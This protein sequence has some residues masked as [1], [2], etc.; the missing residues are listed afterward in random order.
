MA[1]TT[2]GGSGG[3]PPVDWR[4]LG[5]IAGLCAF[6]ILFWDW[7][8][9][10]PVKVFVVLLHELGHATA[11]V[12]T[13]GTVLK[14]EL[15]SD[16]GGVC[17]SAGGWRLLVLPAGYLGSMAL[18][19]LL[20]IAASRVERDRILSYVVGAFVLIVTIVLVRSL[21]GLLFGV[22]FGAAMVAAGRFLS[23]AIN[24]VL[25]KFLGATS[26]LYAII[27]IKDDLIVRT[28]PGS[29]AYQMSK[30]LFLPPVF[31]GILWIAIA[32]VSTVWLVLFSS[33]K[34]PAPPP[35]APGPGRP[36]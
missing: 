36:V 22:L 14:I 24:D 29:D 20:L 25:L 10:Y 21:F 5:L 17:W 13:G 3:R 6:A 35:A 19:G 16:L 30:E 34:R 2:P 7:P 8:F 11:A 4:Q 9:L 28:V 33:R 15:S 1:D 26:C 32:A 31:W 18:G 27:D 23:D 12:L